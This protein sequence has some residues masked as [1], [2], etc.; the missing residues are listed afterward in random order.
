MSLS[1]LEVSALW[2]RFRIAK[3]SKTRDALINHYAYLVKIT[4]G[5]VVTS[6]PPNLERD[7]LIVGDVHA[8]EDRG[9]AAAGDEVGHAIPA[10]ENLSDF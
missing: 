4:S 2:R 1:A 5:R 7:D 3:D 8:L 6:L 9:H 10:I